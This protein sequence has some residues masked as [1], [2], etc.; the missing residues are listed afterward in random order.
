MRAFVRLR[1]MISS[2]KDLAR[3]LDVWSV[4]SKATTCISDLYSKLLKSVKDL[5]VF[6]LAH[7]LAVGVKERNRVRISGEIIDL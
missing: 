6:K 7:Q 4:S 5:H 2:H 3:K 1:E